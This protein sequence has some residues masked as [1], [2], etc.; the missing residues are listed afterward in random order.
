MGREGEK[1]LEREGLGGE[2]EAL[3][4]GAG[5]V[6]YWLLSSCEDKC[7]DDLQVPSDALANPACAQSKHLHSLNIAC[8]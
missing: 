6:A 2:V 8:S 5:R 3:D 7:Q 4:S 1:Q